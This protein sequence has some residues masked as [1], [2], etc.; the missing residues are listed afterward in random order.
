MSFLFCHNCTCFYCFCV[1]HYTEM[2]AIVSST[3]PRF[4]YSHYLSVCQCAISKIADFHLWKGMNL[5]NMTFNFIPALFL[6]IQ[7]QQIVGL[8]FLVTFE[9]NVLY[10][11]N[12]YHFIPML[13][14][15]FV[16][17]NVFVFLHYSALYN[18]SCT[19]LPCS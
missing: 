6:S 17:S 8:F 5:N 9:L 7:L 12:L 2:F 10:N 3:T 13:R 11:F 15:F 18:T 4:Y 16:S 1:P 19:W 14:A